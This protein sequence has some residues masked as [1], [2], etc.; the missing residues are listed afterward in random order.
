[1]SALSRSYREHAV[2][3]EN[4]QRA[5]Q[6]T[7]NGWCHMTEKESKKAVPLL[8]HESHRIQAAYLERLFR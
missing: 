7:E 3:I 5:W 6:R 1:M 4:G 8:L 2:K